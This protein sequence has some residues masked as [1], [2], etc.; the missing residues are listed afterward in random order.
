MKNKTHT[1]DHTIL[2]ILIFGLP[3]QF[4]DINFYLAFYHNGIVQPSTHS[5]CLLWWFTDLCFYTG[6]II[7]MAWLAIERH[8]IIFHDR[9]LSTR[10]GRLLFHYLPLIILVTYSL[11][12]YI[13]VIFFPPCED[14]YDYT[15]PVCNASPCYQSYGIFT[16]WELIVNGSIPIFLEGIASVGL[17]IRVQ[18]QRRRLYQSAQWGKQRRMIIQLFL[19]S[20]LN[21]SFNLPIYFIPILRLCGLPPDFGLQAELYFFFLG[22][23]VIFLF[24]FAS[25]CQYPQL[26]KVIKTRI[27]QFMPRQARHT[28]IVIPLAMKAT[29]MNK[30][31]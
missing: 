2:A 26:R 28:T 24:P 1:T 11:L 14:T 21:M 4:I 18:V 10:S 8:I 27:F 19:V 25:L 13:I 29:P 6:G 12:F 23:F 9:W 22:Y 30:P 15:L 17:I 20:G 3:I 31:A 16:M 5:I 7:L